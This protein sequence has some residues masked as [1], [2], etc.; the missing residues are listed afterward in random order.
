MTTPGNFTIQ[1]KPRLLA[2]MLFA[3]VGL[4]GCGGSGSASPDTGV[5]QPTPDNPNNGG[6]SGNDGGSGN[7]GGSG[8]NGGSGDSGTETQSAQ[9]VASG[10]W[11]DATTWKDGALPATGANI[12]IANGTKVTI[13]SV[14]DKSYKQLMIEGTLAFATDKNTQLKVDTLKSS[15]AGKL[16]IGTP[17]QPVAANVTTKII[18]ADH[19]PVTKATDDKQ[20]SRGA[21]LMGPVEIYGASKTPWLALASHP[22]AGES[23]LELASEPQG[24]QVGDTLVVAATDLNDPTSD[25]VATIAAINGT[26]VQLSAPLAKDH[27]APRTDLAVH[28]ANLSRNIEFSSENPA[29]KHRGHVMFMHN[30]NVDVNFARF[31]QLGRTDKTIPLD[32][33]TFPDLDP[34]LAMALEGNNIRGRYAVHFHRG[35][36]D[37]NSTPARIVGTVVEDNP[38]WAYVNHSSNVDFINNVSYNVVGGAFQTEAGDELGSFINNIALR[39]VNP[40]NPLVE[41]PRTTGRHS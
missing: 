6:G 16:E 19:G 38:G 33:W 26:T 30:L 1:Y 2:A 8:D 23:T 27:I 34:N 39:T 17:N 28:V 24:W 37:L 7:G 9:S 36:V 11:S 13:N 14:L 40:N 20:L 32:D 35:G 5:V 29:V 4:S 15:M 25:D 22:K 21:I 3:V 18:F 41:W 12:V 10:N 31:Y